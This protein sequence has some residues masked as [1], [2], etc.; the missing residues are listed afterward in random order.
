LTHNDGMSPHHLALAVLTLASSRAPQRMPR[1]ARASACNSIPSHGQRPAI[2]RAPTSR[3]RCS[4]PPMRAT[5]RTC[6]SSAA[7]RCAMEGTCEPGGAY[8]RD[9]EINERVRTA[10]A[11][12]ARFAGTSVWVTTT[13]KWVTLQGCVRTPVQRRA[14]VRFVR[15]QPASSACSTSSS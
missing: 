7:W 3:R 5:R 1:T 8:K 6:A 15:A 10:V 12:D 13:R 11:A 9:P 14:L 2:H 4:M